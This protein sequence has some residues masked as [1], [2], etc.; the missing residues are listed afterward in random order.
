MRFGGRRVLLAGCLF[1]ASAYIELVFWHDHT[2]QVLLS[3]GLLGI[4]IAMGYAAMSNLVVEAVPQSQTGVA[5]GM[6]TNIRNIGGAVGAGMAT[7][8]VGELLV[9]G[10]DAEQH[11]YVM[12]FIVSAA[13]LLAAAIV[14]LMIPRHP[15]HDPDTIDQLGAMAGGPS[16]IVATSS[17]VDSCPPTS[18]R[19]LGRCAGMPS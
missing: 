5:T 7:S 14:T 19:R 3:A 11:G 9:G 18:S 4:G 12:A 2:W 6:N 17:R 10:R 8:I 1:S 15:V 13:G 16:A